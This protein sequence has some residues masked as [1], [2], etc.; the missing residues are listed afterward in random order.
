M[1][2]MV[3]ATAEGEEIIA[4]LRIGP[5][6]A[7]PLAEGLKL[8]L[9]VAVALGDGTATWD[10]LG[11][12]RSVRTLALRQWGGPAGQ[13]RWPRQI[14]EDGIALLGKESADVVI[15]SG[16]IGPPGQIEEES[17]AADTS[18]LD[19]FAM[20]RGPKLLITNSRI[21]REMIRGGTL[22]NIQEYLHREIQSREVARTMNINQLPV[23]ANNGN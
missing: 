23:G 12:G 20:P 13:P 14:D 7:E 22:A 5:L 2:S 6:T 21:L 17:L 3:H 19:N 16:Y 11:Q 9:I 18:Y 1:I 15:L 10:D 8:L 4:E